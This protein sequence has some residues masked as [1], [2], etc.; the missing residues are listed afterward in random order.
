MPLS[1]GEQILSGAYPRLHARAGEE[2][3]VA[4]VQ[5]RAARCIARLQQGE[6][7]VVRL[8]NGR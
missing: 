2:Q 8:S 4:Q 6:G 1:P 7:Q 3:S 5:F